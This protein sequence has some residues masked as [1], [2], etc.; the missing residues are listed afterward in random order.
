MAK[1]NGNKVSLATMIYMVA[2]TMG[3]FIYIDKRFDAVENR[4]D[5]IEMTVGLMKQAS[6]DSWTKSD[7]ALWASQLQLS[8]PA[9]VIPS[10]IS[11]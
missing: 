8:N 4:F 3:G 6:N 10:S 9:M 2:A 5:K 7:Q 1:L 11:R